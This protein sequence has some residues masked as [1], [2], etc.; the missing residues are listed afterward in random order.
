MSLYIISNTVI[1]RINTPKGR[2][3]C[4]TWIGR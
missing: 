3:T 1:I 4:V 2:L